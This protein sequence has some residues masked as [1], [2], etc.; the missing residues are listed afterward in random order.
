MSCLAHGYSF[1]VRP[2]DIDALGHVHN[3][4]YL[5]FLVNAIVDAVRSGALPAE[6]E[7]ASLILLFLW[8]SIHLS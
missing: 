4:K 6:Y 8:L 1:A 2:S 3:A 7:Y 5:H